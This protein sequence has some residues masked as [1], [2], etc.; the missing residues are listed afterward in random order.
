MIHSTLE[1]TWRLRN[2]K[3]HL[4]ILHQVFLFP[5]VTPIASANIV[6]VLDIRQ[7]IKK[8]KNEFNLFFF[9]RKG[10]TGS[11]S[12]IFQSHFQWSCRHHRSGSHRLHLILQMWCASLWQW[13][14]A[15]GRCDGFNPPRGATAN[16]WLEPFTALLPGASA[17]GRQ[18][19]RGAGEL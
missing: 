2:F 9:F 6:R 14:G 15:V 12:F 17:T 18:A 1:E 4:P 3:E 11:S 7:E 10:V 13:W 16:C 19:G 8:G 5:H